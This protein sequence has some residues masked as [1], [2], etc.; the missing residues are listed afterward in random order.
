MKPAW[1]IFR[2]INDLI[3]ITP[4]ALDGYQSF[5]GRTGLE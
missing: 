4:L 1:S 5:V 3:A 2:R